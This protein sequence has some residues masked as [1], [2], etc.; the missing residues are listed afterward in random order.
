MKDDQIYDQHYEKQSK[1]SNKKDDASTGISII[2]LLGIFI[3]CF[4]SGYVS[5]LCGLSEGRKNG[6]YIVNS[7]Q[8]PPTTEIKEDIATTNIEK[9]SR[10]IVKITQA[11]ADS[12]VAR[13]ANKTWCGV[14]WASD[15]ETG[16]FIV[17]DEAIA[18]VSKFNVITTDGKGYPAEI[19][20]YDDLIGVTVIKTDVVLPAITVSS[21][22]KI[23]PGVK[24]FSV[25]YSGGKVEGIIT[26]G[27]KKI[28][29]NDVTRFFLQSNFCLDDDV[30]GG[31]L[32]DVQGN[33]V[34]FLKSSDTNLGISYAV[35]ADLLYN[36]LQD[37]LTKGYVT[38]RV[39]VDFMK[40]I[41]IT[42]PNLL[43]PREGL[44]IIELD[45]NITQGPVVGDYI[46][47]ING[48]NILTK[49]E[50]YDELDKYNVLDVIKIT[51][52]HGVETLEFDLT[53]RD[54]SENEE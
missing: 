7:D 46:V 49:K 41:E 9:A 14:V 21:F 18:N 48:T 24:V 32:F 43:Q 6:I 5:W 47:A 42:T 13:S 40:F 22:E 16:S 10:S 27:S 38:G 44:R 35:P 19:A 17:A 4:L 30:V 23:E 12:T 1:V 37:L 33:F 31:G 50:W 29:V 39:Y 26:V 36:T 2:Y 52:L 20:T 34:G 8:T 28:K 25:N 54:E 15:A 51:Y 53:L 11:N 45:T 3:L